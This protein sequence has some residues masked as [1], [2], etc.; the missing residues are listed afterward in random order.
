MKHTW[1]IAPMVFILDLITKVLALR[2]PPEGRT[3]IPGLL[4]LRLTRNT[5][6][7][8]SLLSG[9]PRLLGVLSLLLIAGAFFFL[10][11]KQMS[12]LARAGGMMMMGGAAGNA[13]D[14]LIRG[15]VTDMVEPLFVNFAVFNLADVRLVTGCLM[16]MINLFREQPES[17]EQNE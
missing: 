12:I 7:A 1:W 10:R 9:Y 15:Y 4:G 6:M 14:R 3:L 8:F 17:S 11:K 2:L 16:I 5:G 13:A